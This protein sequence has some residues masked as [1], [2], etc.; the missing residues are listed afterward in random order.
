MITIIDSGLGNL[1]SIQNMLKR[2]GEDSII[3]SN[4]EIIQ[5]AAK[6]ILPGVGKFD[7]G[8]MGLKERNLIPVLNRKVLDE[9]TPILGI[10]LGMQL[11]MNGSDEGKEEG[12]RWIN[13][14]V[15]KFPSA[16]GIKIPHMGWNSVHIQATNPLTEELP[17][18]AKFYFVHSYYV[19]A[20]E[21]DIFL[22][23]QYGIAFVSGIHHKNIY[24]VQFHP[25]KSHK[26]GMKLLN[27]FAKLRV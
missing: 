16:V 14:Y 18:P 9:Q 1:G 21:N 25:E 23:T 8:I 12:L 24:G 3:S 17:L 10:C 22:T 4:P 13:G 2:I 7:A 5:E 19:S 27:N 26:Y 11:F 20:E 6:I 15:H